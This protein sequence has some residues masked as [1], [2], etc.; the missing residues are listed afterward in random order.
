LQEA[1]MIPQPCHCERSEA[2]SVAE[3]Q[4]VADCFVASPLAMTII[5]PARIYFN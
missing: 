4:Q 3:S 1:L 5:D 2:I